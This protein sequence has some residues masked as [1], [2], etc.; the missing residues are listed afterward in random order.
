MTQCS[1][2]CLKCMF[3][4]GGDRHQPGQWHPRAP[5]SLVGLVLHLDRMPSAAIFGGAIAGF[6]IRLSTASYA[7]SD[8]GGQGPVYWG[9]GGLSGGGATSRLLVSYN[10]SI[11]E[12]ILDVLFKP[13][14]GASL[15]VLKV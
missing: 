12:L 2:V 1:S 8:T 14:F 13:A 3:K 11:K 7:V 5:P 10:E 6:L 4:V 15:Q 9:T